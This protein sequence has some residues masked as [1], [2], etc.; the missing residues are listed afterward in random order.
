MLLL[1]IATGIVYF[2]LGDLEEAFAMIGAIAVVVGISF[3]QAQKTER[4]VQALRDLSSPRALVIRDD[5]RIRISGRDVVRGDWVVFHEGDRVPA[6]AVIVEAANLTIDESVLTGESVPVPKHPARDRETSPSQS[7]VYSGTIVVHG[8]GAARVTATGVHTE[9]GRIGASL[10][11]VDVG[12]TGLQR[13]VGRIV[14]L[15]G[16][17][18]LAVCIAVAVAY[19]VNRHQWLDG[20]L[21]GLTVAIS[22][23]PEEFQSCSPRFWRWAPGAS[24]ATAC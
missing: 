3:Y 23:V 10:A 6:D 20:V 5:A 12:R 11:Q 9:L 19:G 7:V 15:L 8:T 24:R 1:L 16:A 22:M 14:R 17:A 4:A 21:A 18:G 2:L 13:E